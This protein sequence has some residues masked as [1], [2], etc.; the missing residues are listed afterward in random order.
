MH[1]LF[2]GNAMEKN[3]KFETNDIADVELVTDKE[4]LYQIARNFLSNAFKFTKKGQVT[5]SVSR[6]DVPEDHLRISVHDT[7]IGIPSDKQ[8][9]IFEAFK[10]ADGTTSREFG[11]TGLGLSIVREL[12]KLLQGEIEV[13]SQPEKGSTFSIII[14]IHINEDLIDEEG[15]PMVIKKHANGDTPAPTAP[16]KRKPAPRSSQPPMRRAV[17]PETHATD[18]RESVFADDK[19]ILIVEDEVQFAEGMAEIIAPEGFKTVIAH[20]GEEGLRLAREYMPDGIILDLGLPDMDGVAVLDRFKSDKE[21]RHIPIEIVSARDKDMSLISKGAIGFLQKPI[22]EASLKGVMADM[23]R[24]TEKTIKD[25]LVVEDDDSQLHAIKELLVGDD[26]KVKGVRSKKEAISEIKKGIYDGAIVDLGLRDGNGQ[27]ICDYINENYPKI[28]VIIY[29]GKSLEP[30]EERELRKAAQ[31]I[32]LKTTNAEDQLKDEVAIFLHRMEKEIAEEKE[33]SKKSR[34][35]ASERARAKKLEEERKKV[36]LRLPEPEKQTESDPETSA[37]ADQLLS[38]IGAKNDI[39]KFNEATHEASS[40]T[41][42]ALDKLKPSGEGKQ[43]QAFIE[44]TEVIKK[45]DE[46][47]A[48]RLIKDRNILVVD[49]DIRNIFVIASALEN[50]EANILEA[51]DGKQALE[52]LEK[53]EVE[54]VMMDTIMPEMDGLETIQHIRAHTNEVIE[55]LPIIAITGK[56]QQQDRE[57]VLKAGANAYIVKPVD[58]DELLNAVCYWLNQ[59]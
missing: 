7:G 34:Q 33:Q 1:D 17:V 49:D 4:R 52:I 32:I 56:A 42:E 13:H 44:P 23:R 46:A 40:N 10:Q 14:P 25:L 8:E 31:S 48:K 47:E 19:L 29:T 54:L 45:W 59:H 20:S 53:E 37:L 9:V 38:E 16:V 28:P 18:D 6:K 43:G 11:G 21:I 51:M 24:L 27:E 55:K 15:I 5:L 41:F 50:F 3:L 26:V 22:D 58:Y 35:E 36:E 12:T 57:E 39:D 30:G 2:M